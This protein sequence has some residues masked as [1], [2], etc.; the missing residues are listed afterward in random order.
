[1]A[2]INSVALIYNISFKYKGEKKLVSRNILNCP[3]KGIFKIYDVFGRVV[4][5]LVCCDFDYS[6]T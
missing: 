3:L 5:S 4:I 1:M 2:C 6:K